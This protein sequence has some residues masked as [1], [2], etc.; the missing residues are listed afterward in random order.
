MHLSRH[1]DKN[2]VRILLLS[3]VLPNADD[4]A[5]WITGDRT[6]VAKSDWKPSLE[7]T[8]FLLWNGES[9]RLNWLGGEKP[10]NPNF[11]QQQP[12]SER[13]NSRKFP[14]SKNEAIAA[15]AVRLSRTGTVL[16]FS[17]TARSVEG[18]ADSVLLA[19]RAEQGSFDWNKNLWDKFENVC[20]E[21]LGGDSIV[22]N[23]ARKGVICHSNKLPTLVRN[24]IERLMRSKQPRI[25]I[26]TST[27]GQGVNVG[28]SSV[29][30]ATPY[31]GENDKISTRDFWNI[32]GRAGRAYTDSE[33]KVLY[34]V[35]RTND[36]K[37]VKK[38]A[39]IARNYFNANYEPVESGVLGALREIKK[40]AAYAGVSFE[41]LVETIANDFSDSSMPDDRQTFIKYVLDLIDD[42]LLAMQEDYTDFL[43]SIDW[44]ETIFKES[45]VLIQAKEEE[46]Q[47][48]LELLK[49]RVS[50]LRQRVPQKAERQAIIATGV[51]FSVSLALLRDTSLFRSI[52]E[53]AM[54]IDSIFPHIDN[55]LKVVK[56]I[57]E[58]IFANA[59]TLIDDKVENARTKLTE[60]DADMIRKKW[61]VGTDLAI[62]NGN[63]ENS[64]EII[65]KL[66]EF[67][68][69]WVIHAISR[70]FDPKTDEEIQKFYSR[71]ALFVELGLP[72]ETAANIYL[73]GVHSRRVAVELAELDSLQNASLLEMKTLLIA[74]AENVE[75][76]SDNAKIWLEGLSEQ[77]NI[78]QRKRLTVRPFRFTSE[79]PDRLLVR[80]NNGGAYLLS[81]DGY[82]QTAQISGDLGAE[83][84]SIATRPDVYFERQTDET[85]KLC[86]YSG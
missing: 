67:V 32:C 45:L 6:L 40:A 65:A 74:L 62:I 81:A 47:Q 35:D 39:E 52:A 83:L 49:A 44:V 64:E 53:A 54:F 37:R 46:R 80:S 58:W 78:E 72:S 63:F 4:L 10:F 85:Y 66:Y 30:V 60:T 8:G 21:E 38:D 7:R 29:I 23:A 69:P 77:Y 26:A 55:S 61:V 2:N 31:R 76:I 50:L 15:T 48:F 18:L 51:P 16:I 33:G 82:F 73:S 20:A 3:A 13:K 68:L 70:L 56:Q 24:A 9:V 12:L 11:V 28:I 71:L 36:I 27:L 79:A 14:N 59:S 41:V 19:L 17:G 34:A 25:I 75:G 42:E 1:A 84:K 5:E 22:L 43:D 57:E 86:T